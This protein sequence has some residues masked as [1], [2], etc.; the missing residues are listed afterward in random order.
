MRNAIERRIDRLAEQWRAFAADP[1]LRLLRW[2]AVADDLRLID[3]FLDLQSEELGTTPD[4]F[5]RLRPPF[6]DPSRYARDL[7]AAFV[8][9]YE[10]ARADLAAQGIAA[11][12]RHREA[13]ADEADPALLVRAAGSFQAYYARHMQCLVLVLAP[14]AVADDR[15]F[16]VWLTALLLRD[17]PPTLRVVVPD[18]AEAPRLD[19]LDEMAPGLAV[20]IEPALDMPGALE[21]LARS[22]GAEGPAKLF[23][24][25]LASLANA[26]GKGNLAAA[27]LAAG[28]ALDVARQESWTDQALVAH[29]AL[30]A[31]Y[32][33]AGRP[34]D[35]V[36]C[37][38]QAGVA[39]EA[40]AKG[41]PA[42]PRLRVTAAMGEAAA[43]VAAARWQEAASAYERAAPLAEAAGDPVMLLEA[44]RMAGWSHEQA[45]SDRD[46]WR[47]GQLAFEAGERL[48]A[49]QRDRSTLPWVGQMLLRLLDRHYPRDDRRAAA[50]RSRLEGAFGKG[51]ERTLELERAIP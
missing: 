29:M 31:A 49:E 15:A 47:C 42:V 26:A 36:G 34:E 8:D 43:L 14:E 3:L 1:M 30:A 20:T 5:V 46:A 19:G 38:R 50:E 44:W 24:V 4:V 6:G 25:Q 33:G 9:Q 7:L 40:A 45:G 21:E 22:E 27:E 51:W 48:P 23:R 13:A 16:S 17:L 18:P 41:H 11:G 28:R 10:A 39:A 37:Y 32:L 2:R 35:A 12:W